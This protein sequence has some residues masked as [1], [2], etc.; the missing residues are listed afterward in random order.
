MNSEYKKVAGI[1]VHKSVLYVVIGDQ[2][3]S[4]SSWKRKRCGATTSELNDLADWLEAEQVSTIVMESTALYWRPVWL[5]LE[6]RF[7]LL[8][9][10]ARSNPAPRGR[11]SDYGDTIRLIKRLGSDD[12]RLSFVPDAEQRDWRLLTRTRVEYGRQIIRL[13]NRLEGLLEEGRIKLSGLLSDLLG[14]S[15]RRILRALADGETDPD[16][17]AELRTGR[18][19]ASRDEF[20]RAL[21]GQLRPTCRLL[22]KQHLEQ[23]EKLEQC[24][25]ELDQQLSQ[26]LQTYQATLERLCEM[27]G[28]AASSAEQ[29]I[30]EIGVTAATFPSPGQLAAWVG[31]CPGREESAGVSKSDASPKGNRFMR[32][33]LN[34]C[35][36]AAARTH[37]SFFET[38][39]NRLVPRL[40]VSKAIWAVAHR[41][42][43]VI[44]RLLH[45]GERYQE[46]GL[47]AHQAETFER[48]F[49][50]LQRQMSALGYRLQLTPP[51][52]GNQSLPA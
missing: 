39:F 40:G 16:K 22:L 21:A 47:L 8:L 52:A 19:Q 20:V 33:I 45:L 29:I 2:D 5:A 1:D 12:L 38:L 32:R 15:G 41:I 7:R 46:K 34:Q 36:W 26:K 31:V 27:P 50:R 9:A 11:K 43:R 18:L 10:Q 14:V 17:L 24:I 48:R 30:A 4:P 13:R 44:W 37:G 51:P 28:L 35:A 25:E 49:R 23:I 42:L 6:K 3:S